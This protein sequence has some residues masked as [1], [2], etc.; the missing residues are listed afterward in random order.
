[1]SYKISHGHCRHETWKEFEDEFRVEFMPEDER[2]ECVLLLQSTAYYQGKTTVDEYI[3][4]F[5]SIVSLAGLNVELDL[6]PCNPEDPIVQARQ[7]IAHHVGE[8][9]VMYFQ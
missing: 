2:N 7:S 1:M 9:V 3:D 8:A 4:S 5:R 6:Y